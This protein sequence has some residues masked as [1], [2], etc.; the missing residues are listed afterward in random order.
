MVSPATLSSLL[1]PTYGQSGFFA[2]A[3]PVLHSSSAA[4]ARKNAVGDL[5]ARAAT[6]RVR[7]H[8]AQPPSPCGAHL[9]TARQRKAGGAEPLACALS[10]LCST[11]PSSLS[12]SCAPGWAPH[13]SFMLQHCRARPA[14]RPRRPSGYQACWAPTRCISANLDVPPLDAR[15]LQRGPTQR[16][17]ELLLPLG[18]ENLGFC[19]EKKKAFS[20]LRHG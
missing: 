7:Q 15:V 6:S 1:L 12:S 13:P 2:P 17:L 3:C 18:I 5:T 14:A 10:L 9:R 16:S 19:N 11:S 8:P 4:I 20:C